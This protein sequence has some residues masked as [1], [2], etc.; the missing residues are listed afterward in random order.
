MQERLFTLQGA[1]NFR[2]LGGYRTI[3]GR[4]IKWRRLFRSGGTGDLTDSDFELLAGLGLKVM[5]DLRATWECEHSPTA[6]ERLPDVTYWCRPYTQSLAQL[7]TILSSE[8]ATAQ[9]ATSIMV[10]IYRALP[11][12]QA[13]AYR[14][15]FRLLADGQL[16]L[17][18]NCTAGKDRTG[19]AAALV[20]RALDVPWNTV[21]EDYAL[22]DGAFSSRPLRSS[23]HQVA[24]NISPAVVKAL[25]G[26]DEI[27]LEAAFAEIDRAFGSFEAY[28]REELAVTRDM[29]ASIRAHLLV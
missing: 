25:G 23:A 24:H 16:P 4:S 14:E 29:S 18:F 1:L 26:T 21:L 3:D 17:V 8:T 28:L 22:S 6:W 2:D 20:L 15:L 11:A 27:Y 10:D 19:V 9:E 13:P 5:F 12:E 7:E